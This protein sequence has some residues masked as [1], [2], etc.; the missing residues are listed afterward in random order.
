MECYR[1]QGRHTPDFP[2]KKTKPLYC[3]GKAEKFVAI[4]DINREL[5]ITETTLD[6][7]GFRGLPTTSPEPEVCRS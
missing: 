5:I 6:T 7:D 3:Y 1:I 2:Q 4:T